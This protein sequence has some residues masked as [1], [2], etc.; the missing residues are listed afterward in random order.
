MN[1]PR[2]AFLI[3]TIILLNPAWA[4]TCGSKGATEVINILAHGIDLNERFK[5]S[6][7][8][9]DKTHYSML[10]DEVEQHGEEIAIPCLF[11]VQAL[12]QKRDDH[13]LMR[14][15]MEF[16]ISNENSADERIS[17][18]ITDIFIM[19][20]KAFKRE[21]KSFTLEQ[22]KILLSSLKDGLL[23]MERPLSVAQRR[24]VERN[25]RLLR[26]SVTR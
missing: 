15:L 8:S 21:W 24:N 6:V 19:Y 22:K 23:S 3:L 12:L 9:G 2:I 4:T 1:I 25:L 5:Q 20:P 17:E 14:K 7:N 11:R 26:E 13:A 10:R 18:A 16:T